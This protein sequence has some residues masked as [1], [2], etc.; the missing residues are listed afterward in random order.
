MPPL[1]KA[2]PFIYNLIYMNNKISVI[3]I[4]DHPLVLSGFEFILN[5]SL[6]IVL[7][8]T[9]AC[10]ENALDFLQEAS[11]D[12]ALVDI[13]LPGMNGIDTMTIINKEY[14][15][16]KVIAISNLNE[17]SIALRMLQAGALG[18]LLKNVS[19]EELI[20]GIHEVYE[21]RQVLSH[22]MAYLM[23]GNLADAV[24]KITERE[25]EVLQLMAQGHTSPKIAD[26]MFISPLTV[27]SH[28]RN[29][30]QKF[31]VSNT[32]SLIHKATEMKFI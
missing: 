11:V 23:N 28:R 12:V 9:F 6:E 22:E 19:A 26:L 30:L 18:Y 15:D 21:G 29:L 17:G 13:N 25:K 20:A 14:P 3:I 27:E 32:A 16:T 2:L 8:G 4:D 10:A 31:E 5:N 1:A 24:P 7:K